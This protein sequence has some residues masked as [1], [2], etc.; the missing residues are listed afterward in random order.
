MPNHTFVKLA[1]ATAMATMFAACT[2]IAPTQSALTSTAELR[3]ATDGSQ[4]FLKAPVTL[5]SEIFIADIAVKLPAAKGTSLSDEERTELSN[6]LRTQLIASLG[7]TYKVVPTPT[8]NSLA[9]QATITD[10]RTSSVAGNIVSTML[11][12][13]PADKGG[14]AAEFELK[15]ASGERVAAMS[16]AAQ[17]KFVQFEG[18]YSRLGQAKLA[19]ADHAKSLSEL[20]QG[21]TNLALS[22]YR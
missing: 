11:L 17:G 15:S 19:L 1:G 7:D 8:K 18:A 10:I 4:R 6:V 2:T 20:L 22:T 16:I 21:Q 3:T 9:L 5:Q 12:F 13:V 14:A